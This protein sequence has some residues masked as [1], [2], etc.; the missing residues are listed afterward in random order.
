MT[1]L[2][3]HQ[4]VECSRCGRSGRVGFVLMDRYADGTDEWRC[5]SKDVCAERMRRGSGGHD[6]DATSLLRVS[7]PPSRRTDPPC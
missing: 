7:R 6:R 1:E 5:R 3:A 4:P 2:A